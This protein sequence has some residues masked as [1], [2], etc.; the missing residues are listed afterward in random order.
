M[1]ETKG[2][3]PHYDAPGHPGALWTVAQLIQGMQ[4]RGDGT[5]I[6]SLHEGRMEP[7][8]YQDLANCVLCL[9]TGLREAGLKP[10]EPAAIYCSNSPTWIAVALALNA[11]GALVVPIDDL[12]SEERAR[13]VISDSG[14]K[15]VFSTRAHLAALRRMPGGESSRF[16]QLDAPDEVEAGAKSWL[17]LRA[18]TPVA[19][20]DR[21]PDRPA[22]LFYTSGTTGPPKAFILTHANIG[23]NVRALA[24]AALVKPGDRV[25][26]P[27]P[28]HH[29]YP[30]IV[31]M[32]TSLETGVA[33]V[34]PQSVTGPHIAQA[35][36]A[37][38]VTV[39]IGV[40][41]LY[42]A[43]L[44]GLEVRIAAHG[45]VLKRSFSLLLSLCVWMQRRLGVAVGRWLLRPIRRQIA[46]DL[47]LLVSGGAKLGADLSWTLEALGW[48]ALAGYGLAETASVFTANLPRRKRLGS[49]G[50]P[51][52]DGKVRIANA[53]ETGA[54]EIELCGSS[55]TSGYL[56]NPQAN[57]AALTPDGWFRTGDLGYLD[58]DGFLF[59]TGR[60][61][62]VIVLGGGKK[63]NPEELEK[64]Y[65]AN[66]LIGEIAVLER[67]GQLAGLVRPNP[68]QL[69]RIGTMNVEH[70]I[71]VALAETAQSLPAYGRLAG[72]AV[73]KQPLPRTRLGKYQRFLL[74]N[75]Y[76]EASSG[77]SKAPRLELSAE[78]RQFL[79]NPIRAAAW[80]LVLARYSAKRPTLDS[81][82]ALDLG[83]DSLEW[84]GL[85]LD[86]EAKLGVA[87]SEEDMA[88]IET[89]RG[90]LIA[91]DRAGGKP[92]AG[93][94]ISQQQILADRERWL[95]PR[96]PM[97]TLIGLSLFTL[98]KLL[99]R[100]IFRL[101]V[102]GT[103]HLP[104][105]GAYLLV[106]NHISDLDPL[107]IAAAL[108]FG[109]L[110]R[111]YW[112]GDVVRL[113]G[114]AILRQLCRAVHL[115]PVDERM[116]ASAID[117]ASLVLSRGNVQVWFPEGWRSPDGRLQ[118][119]LPGIGSVVA[120][121][122]APVVPVYI[123]G[124]FQAMP[125]TRRWPRPSPIR[126]FFGAPMEA[127][128]LVSHG[129]G[130]TVEERVASA[131]QVAVRALAA[132]AG[133]AV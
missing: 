17:R 54:G 95:R 42:E 63:V 26:V 38:R 112:A 107:A 71:R 8:S 125:R 102:Q 61:K 37:A 12:A 123:S 131:L 103:E 2:H 85:S 10:E 74:A 108:P 15:W 128:L 73:A 29:A 122:R 80:N 27:L 96:G 124:T 60:A 65:A 119:F 105:T 115:C 28:L 4:G 116:P 69:R 90:L 43:L 45:W 66:P 25:L 129:A 97:L 100:L 20:P 77:V 67:D 92:G 6:L 109:R 82:L 101:R 121:T 114:N 106:P 51:L 3:A 41:R 70:A 130:E 55:V 40:P 91:L 126:V 76:D 1:N 39:I 104:Q 19:I 46:P 22:C 111:V 113:F 75:L 81:H 110:R 79:A 117:T 132:E 87:L 14:A 72:F 7:W 32:L 98:N 48:Q 62:E 78:E 47:R 24:A 133:E 11:V 13:S 18:A 52:A 44:S 68:E 99:M 84:M 35:L 50:T 120:K 30:Y 34:L 57:R 36:R 83:V 93:R 31:G 118:R 89:V 88:G 64:A 21:Q 5:A 16:F 23:T 127:D 33:I 59:V 56:H 94:Q 53:D 9:A 49:A 58:Q 86:L